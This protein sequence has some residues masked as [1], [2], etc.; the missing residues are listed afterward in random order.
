MTALDMWLL[1][2][3]ITLFLE[4]IE[5]AIVLQIKFSNATLKY[6]VKRA[7]SKNRKIFSERKMTDGDFEKL[8]TAK[9]KKIDSGALIG[10]LIGS[11]FMNLVYF[12]YYW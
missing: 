9:C 6:P 7:S 10:L 8:I 4:L 12:I 11:I 5:Y 1:I 2:A 3:K